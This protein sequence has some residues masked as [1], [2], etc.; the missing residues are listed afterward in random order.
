M[1]KLGIKMDKSM[2]FQK[3]TLVRNNINLGFKDRKEKV[4]MAWKA[5]Q[6]RD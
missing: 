5:F 6:T 4:N 1:I 2:T 3:L